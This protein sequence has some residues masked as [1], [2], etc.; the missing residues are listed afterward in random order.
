[1]RPWPTTMFAGVKPLSVAVV[2]VGRRR[3]RAPPVSW[4]E[5]SSSEPVDALADGQLALR[6]LAR[7][8]LLAAHLARQG[9]AAAQ[10]LELGLPSSSAPAYPRA[11]PRGPTGAIIDAWSV[12]ATAPWSPPRCSPAAAGAAA[13]HDKATSTATTPPAATQP[14]AGPNPLDPPPNVPA[15]GHRHGPTP[16]PRA[17]SGPGLAPCGAATSRRPPRYFSLPSK[18]QNATPVL[19]IDIPAERIAINEA[20]P[21]GA[22]PI[23]LGSAGAF[24]IVTFRLVDARRRIAA[25]RPARR[26]A[27]RSA[28]PTATSASGTACPTTPGE[29]RLAGARR[30]DAADAL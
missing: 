22:V 26:P 3:R 28:S 18:F 7:D 4:K 27:P 2:A 19:T 20:L 17:S 21:C 25:A 30:L 13:A 8:A 5:P 14:K 11:S 12:P 23:K 9:L 16:S 15:A 1:M 29:Q 6:V 24:T 10:L